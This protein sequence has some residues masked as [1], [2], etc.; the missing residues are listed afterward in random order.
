MKTFFA[1]FVFL[2]FCNISFSQ[3]EEMYASTELTIQITNAPYMTVYFDLIPMGANWAKSGTNDCNILLYNNTITYSSSLTAGSTGYVDCNNNGYQYRFYNDNNSTS[4]GSCSDANAG[5]KPI[6]NGFYRINVTVNSELKTFVYFDWRDIGFNVGNCN[7]CPYG[8]D[9][10]IRYDNSRGKLLFFNTGVVSNENENYDAILDDGDI[11]TWADWKCIE[12]DGLNIWWNNNLILLTNGNNPILRWGP[13]LNFQ[14]TNYKI[15]RAASLSPLVHPEI[16]ASVIATVSNSTFEY[17]DHD[18]SLSTNGEYLY[19]FVKAYNGSYS[20]ATNTVQ[21]RG[22]FYKENSSK[23]DEQKFK[24][25]LNQNYPNPFNPS[26]K[27]VYTIPERAFVSL[28]IYDILG[29]VIAE[30]ENRIKEPGIYETDFNAENLPSGIY[31]YT[32]SANAQTITKK[33]LFVK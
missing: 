21:V 17:I 29:N 3:D 27:I 32:L 2:S 25:N 23:G 16:Y 14:A 11:I 15:Y 19:Y 9:M 33:M 6:R 7:D 4:F 22:Y 1:F 13:Y 12:P 26:T 20:G 8:N 24:F 31:F 30:L 28:K 5:I 10:T 18:I